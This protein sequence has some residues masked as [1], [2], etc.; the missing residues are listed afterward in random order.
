MLTQCAIDNGLSLNLFHVFY[1]T[2]PLND[3]VKDLNDWIRFADTE[4]CVKRRA[5]TSQAG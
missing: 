2:Q 5:V 1:S 4:L 3:M